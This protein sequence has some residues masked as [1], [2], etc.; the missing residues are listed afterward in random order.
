MNSGEQVK[1]RRIFRQQRL[2][3]QVSNLK[4]S[5]HFTTNENMEEGREGTRLSET[6]VEEQMSEREPWPLG[7]ANAKVNRRVSNR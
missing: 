5:Y 6:R 2:K 1:E 3:S 4:S 7:S